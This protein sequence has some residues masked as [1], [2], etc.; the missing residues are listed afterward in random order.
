MSA[1]DSTPQRYPR[2]QRLIQWL[3]YAYLIRFA[4][5]TAVA[6]VGLPFASFFTGARS[7][8]EN[9]F[10]LEPL[11]VALVTMT[12]LLAAWSVMV[13]ARLAL[14][15]GAER[16]GV[17]QA[18][19]GFLLGW[20]HILLFGLLAAPIIAG[21]FYETAKLWDYTSISMNRW[22]IVAVAPGILTALLLLWVSDLL[23][24]RLNSPG[25]N[26]L[27]PDLLMPSDRPL[28]RFLT[29]KMNELKPMVAAPNWLSKWMKS[30]PDFFGRGYVDYEA[31]PE[32]RFPLLPGHGV[33]LCLMLIFLV[34]YAVVGFVTSPWMTSLRTPSL[35]GVL[36][37]L[38]MLNWGLSGL[39]YFFDRYRIPV[40]VSIAILLGFASM[41]FPR[42]DSYYFIYPKAA[43]A[44]A[45]SAP[46]NLI[47]P[48]DGA[49]VILVA[50]NGGGIQASAWTA[51]VLTGVEESCRNSGDCG[52]RS[53]ARSVRLIS[54]VSGGSVGAMYFAN[55]YQP[56]GNLPP[57]QNA[58]EEIVRLAARSS[59]DG[60]AWG[61]VYPDFLRTALPFLSEVRFFW[62]TDRGRALE[63]EW[64]RGVAGLNERKLGQ[65]RRDAMMGKRPGVVFNATMVDSGRPLLFST[66]DHDQNLSVAKT[67]D[68]LYPGY[69]APVT[70]AVRLSATFPYVTPAARAHRDGES[71]L[72]QAEYHVVDGGYYDNYG[73]ATLVEWLDRELQKSEINVAE[74]MVIRIHSM[75]VGLERKPG[76][77]RGF[78]YQ[79][80]A[81]L[82]TLNNVRGAGQLSHSKVEFDLLQKRWRERADRKV[83]IDLATFEYPNDDAPLSWHLTDKQKQEIEKAWRDKFVNDPNSDLSKVKMFLAR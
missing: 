48:R 10:D 82:L 9:L 14:I 52:G 60:V 8:L 45:E 57:D 43:S 59:L 46:Q 11:A 51:R 74:L 21:V 17:A 29:Q 49:K 70:S 69:D 12:A 35:A 36:L 83:E 23:Q 66:I 37:L 55:A 38:T 5:L 72:S 40:L 31:D 47:G 13:T 54:A 71:D 73:M 25:T 34:V 67:F 65:W 68:K 18:K 79:T 41:I 80:E 62:R 27:A 2:L 53:F 61:L 64:R 32:D 78:F 20:R 30:I 58:L 77:S 26:R 75:P 24:R 7:L 16:F 44:E 33:A 19:I 81:P 28:T 39:A 3:T 1:T 76:D 6:L 50:A 15:Y 63:F 42:S 4:L 22:K 56:D